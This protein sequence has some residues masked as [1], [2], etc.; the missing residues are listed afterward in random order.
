MTTVILSETLHVLWRA[1]DKIIF[2][3][4]ISQSPD[5]TGDSAEKEKMMHH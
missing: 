3:L 5:I 2:L 1:A 4:F